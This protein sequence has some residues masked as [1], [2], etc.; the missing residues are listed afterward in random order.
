MDAPFRGIGSPDWWW[1]FFRKYQ[2]SDPGASVIYPTL[3]IAHRALYDEMMDEE[4]EKILNPQNFI[5]T[6]DDDQRY[7]EQ[8]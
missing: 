4:Q 8:E 2:K 6:G 1:K 7:F 3:T 5:N